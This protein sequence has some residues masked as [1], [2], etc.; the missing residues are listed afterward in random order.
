MDK[1]INFKILLLC[2]SFN[3]IIFLYCSFDKWVVI[4]Q[5]KIYEDDIEKNYINIILTGFNISLDFKS[6]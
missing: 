5:E 6:K 3:I 4:F 2:I 1:L